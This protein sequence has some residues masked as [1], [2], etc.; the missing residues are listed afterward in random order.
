MTGMVIV[1]TGV[2]EYAGASDGV[3]ITKQAF[4]TVSDWFP[5]ILSLVVFLFAFSTMLTYSYYGQQ[6][7]LYAIKN[8]NIKTCHII[9][10]SFVFIGGVLQLNIVVDFADIL[11][12]S[13][14]IPNLIGLY[15]LRDEIK[16]E[17]E[18][19]IQKLKNKEFT[20]YK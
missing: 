8:A 16:S 18:K 6:A 14:A 20:V 9:F 4:S 19:Y 17:S 12:L 10:V 2:Y 3:L 5:Y 11:F 15:I 13:M 1:V 7:W